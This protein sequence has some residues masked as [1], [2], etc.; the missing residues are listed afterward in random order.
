MHPIVHSDVTYL[1]FA[2]QLPVCKDTV[3]IGSE[4]AAFSTVSKAIF[5]TVPAFHRRCASSKEPQLLM[6]PAWV[7]RLKRE[8]AGRAMETKSPPLMWACFF[9]RSKHFKQGLN[10]PAPSQPI[11]IESPS[12]PEI[13]HAKRACCNTWLPLIMRGT[14]AVSKPLPSIE[15]SASSWRRKKR[16]MTAEKPPLICFS[17]LDLTTR[18]P[19]QPLIEHKC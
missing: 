9:T 8:V 7:A 12:P 3:G 16:R 13:R 11:I 1:Y 19:T 14:P 6:M 4:P 5:V 2:S 17:S 18:G 15:L 10:E